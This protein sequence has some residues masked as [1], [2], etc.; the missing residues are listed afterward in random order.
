MRNEEDCPQTQRYLF[1][2]TYLSDKGIDLSQN[3]I[4][5]RFTNRNKSESYQKYI[6][7]KRK[8]NEIIVFTMYAYADLKINKEF[9]CIFNY[10]NPDEFVLE[11]FIL[12]QSIYEGWVPTD[13][14]DE[15]HKH[16][17]VLKFENEIPK[18]LFKLHKEETL[19]DTRP[20]IYTKLGFC[21]KKDFEA[22]ATNI[23]KYHV[24]RKKYGMEYWK[25]V[26]EEI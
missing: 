18:I 22:I 10:D 11:K 3:D 24:L 7:W 13:I 16:L 1:C 20:K 23:K 8:S 21:N 15:G 12:T 25:Y 9:D 2:D 19:G 17:L 26:D 14:V 5:K 6:T 4:I